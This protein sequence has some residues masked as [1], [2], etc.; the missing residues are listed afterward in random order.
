MNTREEIYNTTAKEVTRLKTAE[1]MVEEEMNIGDIMG[2]YLA[3]EECLEG[4][5]E[6]AKQ[7][8]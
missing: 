2:L 6:V 5:F 7:M 1:R 8:I 4:Y 3:R